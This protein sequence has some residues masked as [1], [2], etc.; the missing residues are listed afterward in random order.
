VVTVGVAD[1]VAVVGKVA[2]CHH[3]ARLVC[4]Y[5]KSLRY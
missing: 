4:K 1:V 2:P 3:N 5:L